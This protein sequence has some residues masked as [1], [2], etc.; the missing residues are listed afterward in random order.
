MMFVK[1]NEERKS[2][3]P[4]DLCAINDFELID[5]DSQKKVDEWEKQ[6]GSKGG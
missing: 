6:K 2:A 4:E 3:A 1:F 5:F